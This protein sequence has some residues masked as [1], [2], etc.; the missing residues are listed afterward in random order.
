MARF[1]N[2]AMLGPMAAILHLGRQGAYHFGPPHPSWSGVRGG[3][4]RAE[5]SHR[6]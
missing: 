6:H 2:F 5:V 3:Q 4:F 1:F